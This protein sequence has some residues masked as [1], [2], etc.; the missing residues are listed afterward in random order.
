MEFLKHLQNS[1]AFIDDA[2]SGRGKTE[3][4]PEQVLR[5]PGRV[6]V[7]C[8]AGVSRSSSIVIH[9]LLTHGLVDSYDNALAVVRKVRPVAQPNEG[10]E[11]Q[12]RTVVT[13]REHSLVE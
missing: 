13:E 6:L 11:A 3:G 4:G 12:L 7:H 10:F 9:Y 5:R 8:N 2:L 1:D